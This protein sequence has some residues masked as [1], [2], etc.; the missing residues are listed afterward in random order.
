MWTDA[1]IAAY[2][3]SGARSLCVEWDGQQFRPVGINW[4]DAPG[5]EHGPILFKMAGPLH[6]ITAC[7]PSKKS[8]SS[9]DHRARPF[10]R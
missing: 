1:D 6:V 3:R 2:L 7:D 8:A 10:A 9:S 5:N 4:L